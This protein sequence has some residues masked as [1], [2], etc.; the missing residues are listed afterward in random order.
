MDCWKDSTLLKS[1]KIPIATTACSLLTPK[2]AAQTDSLLSCKLESAERLIVFVCLPGSLRWNSQWNLSFLF[3][4]FQAS[5][6]NSDQQVLHFFSVEMYVSSN[7]QWI[8]QK[9]LN[10]GAKKERKSQLVSVSTLKYSWGSALREGEI[11]TQL[12]TPQRAFG[13]SVP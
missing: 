9:H 11:E 2:S 7:N 5:S 10:A 13:G 6:S 8:R 3:D 4:F 12:S 1:I